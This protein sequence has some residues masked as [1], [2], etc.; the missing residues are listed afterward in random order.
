MLWRGGVSV[1]TQPEGTVVLGRRGQR[2]GQGT[3]GPLWAVA[4]GG[5]RAELVQVRE[6]PAGGTVLGGRLAGC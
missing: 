3:G 4:K 2:G 5:L 1:F 6:Q